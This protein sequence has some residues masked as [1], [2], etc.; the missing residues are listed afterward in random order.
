MKV[1][2]L[3]KGMLLKF[4]EPRYYKFLRDNGDDH[5]LECGKMDMTQTIRGGLR[6][7][8]PLMIYLG[9]QEMPDFSHYGRFHRVRKISVDGKTAMMWPENWKYVEPAK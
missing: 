2:E 6:L 1:S 9:Q 4:T 5:W 7:G 8:R 3:K